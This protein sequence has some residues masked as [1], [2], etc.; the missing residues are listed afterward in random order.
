MS[1]I[2]KFDKRNAKDIMEQ[3]K[4]LSGKYTPEWNFDENS[5]DFGVIL[6]KVY[7]KMMENTIT[8]YNKM[9]YN[10]YLTFL[11]TLGTKLRPAAPSEGIVTVATTAG[12]EPIYIEKGSAVYADADTEDGSVVYETLDSLTAVD[13][14]VSKIY[15]TEPDSDFIGCVYGAQKDSEDEEESEEEPEDAAENKKVGSFRIFDNIYYENLQAHEIYIA[16]DIVF[17]M[18][19]TDIEFSLYNN[20]SAKNQKKLPEIFSDSKNVTWEYYD[21]ENWKK[22]DSAEKTERGIRIKF[23][24]STKPCEVHGVK[25]RYIRCIFKKIPE[26]GV[27]L[28]SI[29]Y[30]TRSEGLKADSLFANES[31]L[32][33][34]DFYPFDEQYSL[35]GA[36]SI[37]CDEALTKKGAMVELAVDMQFVKIKTDAEMPGKRYKIIMSDVDF[38]DLDP[39][40]IE[41]QKVKWEYWNGRGWTALRVD[42]E[43]EEFFSVSKKSKDTHRVLKFKCPSDIESISVGSDEGNFIRARI[44]KMKDQFDFYANYITPYIHEA[45]IK[46]SYGEEGHSAKEIVVK[47]DMRENKIDISSGS[48]KKIAERRLCEFPAMYVCLTRPLSQGMIRMMIDIEDGIHRY[49][50]TLK[51][52]YLADDHKG[53]KIW[54][55]LDV[56]DGTDAFSHSETVTIIGQNDFKKAKIFDAEGYFLRIIN[57]DKKYSNPENIAGR[58]VINDIKFNAVR[59]I[60]RDTQEPEYFSIE[61]GEED[62]ICNLAS[63]NASNA[64]VWV[65]ECENIS[66]TEQEKL[67]S[68][69]RTEVQP[70]YDDLGR[71][72]NL[73]VKWK[74]VSNLI[75]YGT[76]DRVY[77]IDYSQGTVKFGNGKNGKIPSSQYSESI[78]VQYC[79]CSGSKGNI[80]SRKINDFVISIGNIDKV[81]NPTP[82]MGGVDMETIDSA[83]RRM[84][85]QISGGNRIVSVSDFEDAICFNDRNIYKVKCLPHINEQSEDEI[86]VT[87]VSVLP[88]EFMKGYE[89]FQGIKNKIWQF[90]DEKAPV[91]LANSGRLRIFEVNYVETSVSLEVAIDDFNSYQSVYKGIENK[92]KEFLNPISGNFSRKGWGIGDFPRKELIYNYIKALPG[93][94]WIKSINVFTQLVTNEGKKEVDYEKVKYNKFAVPVYGKP[95]I[96]ITVN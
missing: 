54:K 59:V 19:K 74:P 20:F 44:V 28:T 26:S 18:A 3:I 70:V 21:G 45:K 52:E 80:D 27:S 48:L 77:E 37:K 85:S 96:N 49:N 89:K 31:D 79:I 13:T 1:N 8:K 15:F 81:E 87:S 36:F 90:I 56:M 71:L 43:A 51:W 69:P 66:T 76:E 57:P 22:V 42:D 32:P 61:P 41:I 34:T 25:S 86:G 47:S 4:E 40:D 12:S 75:A 38:A 5:D 95:E 58:P 14:S 64:E 65:D 33:E 46:Y 68:M 2:P 73:W 29:K 50:P 83:A 7:S 93:L 11:N 60:Q 94:K 92:L 72:E 35:Y 10:Y 16:D 9:S 17:D 23:E 62:K 91:T 84:F 24:G 82:I 39:K 67:L 55:H 6:S 78:K 53:G 63:T 30:Q 88:R